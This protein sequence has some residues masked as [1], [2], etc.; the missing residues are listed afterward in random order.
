MRERP[1]GA[2]A[3]RGRIRPRLPGRVQLLRRGAVDPSATARTRGG[4]FTLRLRAPRPGRYQ[5]VFIPSGE[6]AERST[7]NAGV[8]R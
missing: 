8:I 2:V 5:V 7:S 6:R 3:V 4:R 1:G